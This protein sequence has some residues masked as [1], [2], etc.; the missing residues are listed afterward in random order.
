MD[1]IKFY[2]VNDA[3]GS[4]SNFAPSPIVL[5]SFVWP[6]VEHFFQASKFLDYRIQDKI[7]VLSSPMDAAKEGRN[8]AYPL[9][10]DWETVK[11]SVMLRA[12]R[13]KFFQHHHL[14]VELMETGNAQLIEHTIN[15]SYWADGGNGEGKNRLGELLMQVRSEL[16]A[17]HPNPHM[18]LPPW[19]SFPHI[20]A[21]DLFWRMGLGEDALM[22][23]S[24]YYRTLPD[25][26]SYQQQ[27][28]EPDD[29]RGEYYDL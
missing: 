28:P 19:I 9:R 14:K 26:Q 25:K 5:A 7:R 29:R 24:K 20:D 1:T 18:I 11:D 16:H 10:D 4:F 23:W 8:R 3:Y 22:K 15:D 13:A 21:A 12:L 27:F 6:T 17:L 2:R